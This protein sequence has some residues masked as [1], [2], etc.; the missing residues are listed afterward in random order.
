MNQKW[1]NQ[2]TKIW[3]FHIGEL[4]KTEERSRGCALAFEDGGAI[5]FAARLGSRYIV[6][7]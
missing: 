4:E 3:Y 2:D 7:I 1:Q 5:L 6:G